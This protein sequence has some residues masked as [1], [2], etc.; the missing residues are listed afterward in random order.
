MSA[1]NVTISHPDYGT[2]QVTEEVAAYQVRHGWTRGTKGTAKVTAEANT[3]EM[4]AK[5]NDLVAW[6]GDDPDRA[7]Q[8]KAAEDALGDKARQTVLDHIAKVT[9]EANTD[10]EATASP[11]Q[12]A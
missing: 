7:A 5:A 3:D 8:A 12:E 6:I 1:R 10:P 11:S 4:P 2:A 9:A